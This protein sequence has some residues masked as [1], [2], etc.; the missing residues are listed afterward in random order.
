[1]SRATEIAVDYRQALNADRTVKS[2][3]ESDNKNRSTDKHRVAWNQVDEEQFKADLF[4]LTSRPD[5]LLSAQFDGIKSFSIDA[6]NSDAKHYLRLGLLHSLLEYTYKDSPEFKPLKDA[7]K[8]LLDMLSNPPGLFAAVKQASSNISSL[9]GSLEELHDGISKARIQS[10]QQQVMTKMIFLMLESATKEID[11]QARAVKWLL[12]ISRIDQLK[13]NFHSLLKKKAASEDKNE[14]T[15]PSKVV[16]DSVDTT[17]ASQTWTEYLWSCMPSSE[18]VGNVAE[19]VA[20]TAAAAVVIGAAAPAT[21]AFVGAAAVAVQA[22]SR[23]GPAWTQAPV[24]ARQSAS[25]PTVNIK[26]TLANNLTEYLCDRAD[27]GT[28]VFNVD[29]YASITGRGF[30]AGTKVSAAG[31]LIN[32]LDDVGSPSILSDSSHEK[33]ELYCKALTTGTLLKTITDSKGLPEGIKNTLKGAGSATEKV[34]ALIGM[35][36][37]QPTGRRAADNNVADNSLPQRLP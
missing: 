20:Y 26:D 4:T 13:N 33:H 37:N 17:S 19:S 32:L 23:V 11:K 34:Q 8:P 14:T 30:T 28:S 1:M 25:Q 2:L 18:T 24:A 36:K 22:A 5:L 3:F 15:S 9:L 27:K 35:L 21:A 10:E 31:E 7:L 6:A 12:P 16:V 29:W